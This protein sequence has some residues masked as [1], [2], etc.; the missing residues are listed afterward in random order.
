MPWPGKAS[1]FWPCQ[2]QASSPASGQS[3]TGLQLPQPPFP[4]SYSPRS[5]PFGLRLTPGNI[6]EEAD[7]C[8]VSS[9][10]RS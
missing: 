9:H 10:P 5:N 2:D 1:G 7:W 3:P 6:L 8:L 4:H